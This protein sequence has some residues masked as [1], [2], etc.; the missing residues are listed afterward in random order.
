MLKSET[1][2]L[3]D[4]MNWYLA[5]LQMSCSV[6]LE[7]AYQV[8]R[9]HCLIA[10]DNHE[11]AHQKSIELGNHLATKSYI[12]EGIYDLLLINDAPADRS[13]LSWSQV[14]LTPQ[15]LESEISQKEQMRAFTLRQ[16]SPSGW[17]I[18]YVVLYEDHDEGSH[19]DRLLVWINSHLI[20]ANDADTAY[21]RIVQLL[22]PA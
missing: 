22:T 10:G 4:T 16:P 15:E 2:K 17:Y 7:F 14:E 18:G 21:A 8:R 9:C 11:E 5:S 20:I 6:E 3:D 13:E 12:F 1:N 19:G